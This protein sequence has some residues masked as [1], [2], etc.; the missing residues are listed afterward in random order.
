MYLEAKALKR[1]FSQEDLV[2]RANQG[3]GTA[4]PL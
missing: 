3:M 1:H 4:E 2:Q